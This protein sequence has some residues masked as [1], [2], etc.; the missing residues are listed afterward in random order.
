[1]RKVRIKLKY[2]NYNWKR[3]KNPL[4]G[5]WYWPTKPHRIRNL[6]LH[7]Y[8]ESRTKILSNGCWDWI[9][10]NGKHASNATHRDLPYGYGTIGRAAWYCFFGEIRGKLDVCH[11]CDNG[12]CVN[13]MHLFLGTRLQ[14]MQDCV[15]KGRHYHGKKH[16][17]AKLTDLK[18][19]E[20]RK[21]REKGLTYEQL[22]KKFDVGMAVAWG[23][24]NKKTWRHVP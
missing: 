8:L 16:H 11:T 3:V 5:Q 20:M 4:T 19:M 17:L 13:P 2:K 15:S 9:T 10:K 22:G 18:V 21:L 6:P 14:N 12:H 23:I 1:M 24:V 7:L